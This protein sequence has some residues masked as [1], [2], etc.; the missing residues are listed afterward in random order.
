EKNSFQVPFFLGILPDL[1]H[2]A[3]INPLS[4]QIVPFFEA[5]YSYAH[6]FGDMMKRIPFPHYICTGLRFIVMK[7]ECLAGLEI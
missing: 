2:L 5:L 3:G 7:A 1:K 6:F 4:F